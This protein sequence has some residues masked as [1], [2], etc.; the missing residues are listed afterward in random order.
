MTT[1]AVKMS[2]RY[3]RKAFLIFSDEDH[4]VIRQGFIDESCLNAILN[5]LFAEV[6]QKEGDTDLKKK[7]RRSLQRSYVQN[8][9]DLL[10][11]TAQDQKNYAIQYHTDAILYV[12]QN[13][14]KVE[15]YC[16][17]QVQAQS[18]IN[19]LHYEDLLR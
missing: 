18:G 10:N 17:Q 7:L 15:D 11:P 4:I 14:Q 3:S 12:M 5:D 1:S 6:W 8:L 9:N 19:K 16:K 2:G 13:L